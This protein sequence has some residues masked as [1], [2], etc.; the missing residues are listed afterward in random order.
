MADIPVPPAKPPFRRWPRLAAGLAATLVA[1]WVGGL[2]WFVAA[3]P[4]EAADDGG[5]TDAIVVLTGGVGRLDAGLHLLAEGRARK[6]FVSGVYRGVDVSQLLRLSRQAPDRLQ[7]CIELGHG[8]VNTA[9]NAAETARWMRAQGFGSLR[10]VTSSYH[11]PR[12]VLEFRLALPGA[13]IIPH[14]VFS[15]QVKQAQWWAWPGTA[16]LIVGEYSKYLLALLRH[17]AGWPVELPGEEAK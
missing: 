1:A 5:T 16:S 10:L 14:P 15:G 7:C 13:A 2:L 3:I 8:A 4:D 12:S 17:L 6:L 9:G 11:M